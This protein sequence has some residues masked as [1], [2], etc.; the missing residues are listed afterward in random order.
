MQYERL[1][2]T[3]DL[4]EIFSV[5]DKTIKRWRKNG[6]LPFVQIGGAIRF[7]TEDVQAAIEAGASN[8]PQSIDPFT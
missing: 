3:K 5:S 8:P 2:T 1:L 7:R 4:Q 6:T